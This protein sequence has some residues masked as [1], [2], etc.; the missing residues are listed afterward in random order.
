M[1]TQ[2]VLASASPR[3]HELLS[4][5]G[6]EFAV[7]PADVDE[8][9]L[10]YGEPIAIVRRLAEAKAGARP[11]D[12]AAIGADT[13]VVVDGAILGKPADAAEARSMLRTLSGREHDVY[14]GVCVDASW[15]RPLG[16]R[17][18]VAHAATA[19][20]FRRLSDHEIEAWIASGGPFDKAGA[21]GVQDAAFRPVA[22]YNGCYCNVMGLPLGVTE[23]LLAGFDLYPTREANL[24]LQCS[25]CPV[26]PSSAQGATQ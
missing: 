24:P 20:A 6:F 23:R 17:P 11:F 2:L 9:S 19:V 14:T 10:T 12:G 26:G 22:A 7:A 21:Y 5:L 18:A 25:T 13:I 1:A 8:A 3:R 4:A 16:R 15:M